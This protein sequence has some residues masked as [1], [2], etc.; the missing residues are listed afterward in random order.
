[1]KGVFSIKKTIASVL[2]CISL[3]LTSSFSALAATNVST[4]KGTTG[5]YGVALSNT[6]RIEL[7]YLTNSGTRSSVN[8][9]AFVVKQY[10]GSEVIQEVTGYVGGST[11]QIIDYNNGKV[12]KQT[13]R[14]ISDMVTKTSETTSVDSLTSAA[15]NHGTVLGHIIYNKSF[16]SNEE[17]KITVY[18]KIT[19]N[20]LESFRIHALKTDSINAIIAS[21][22]GAGLGR[23]LGP[24]IDIP[25]LVTSI[26]TGLGGSVVGAAIG[27][28]IDES[29]AVDATYY[30]LTG[31]YAPTNYYSPG[32]DGIARLVKT[33]Q[34]R[35]YNKWFYEGFTPHNWKEGPL[36][37]MLYIG[38]FGGTYPYVKEYR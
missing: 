34:S 27:I 11:I 18:S 17:R 4:D 5:T 29:V 33:Q 1:M 8:G 7:T 38:T 23:V 26:V 32:Y 15:T 37:N 30:T 24:L 3:L 16:E 12:V 9:D 36:A 22:V 6:S 28:A 2:I 13:T 25:A 19:K 21:V 35:V 10:E 20:D 14:N 31:Y